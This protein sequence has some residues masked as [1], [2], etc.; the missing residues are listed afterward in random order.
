M[1]VGKTKLAIPHGVHD[2]HMHMDNTGLFAR[3]IVTCR[4]A[5]QNHILQIVISVLSPHL[6]MPEFIQKTFI[7]SYLRKYPS[8]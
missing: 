2:C 3:F 4:N 6:V 5:C 7:K 1:T 8:C